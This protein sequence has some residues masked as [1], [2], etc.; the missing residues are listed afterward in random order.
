MEA[1]KEMK[2][3]VGDITNRRKSL[4]KT[5]SIIK[6]LREHMKICGNTIKHLIISTIKEVIGVNSIK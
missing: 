5:N 1:N 3:M 6:R 2:V 4:M